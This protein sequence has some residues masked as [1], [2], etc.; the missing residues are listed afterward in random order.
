MSNLQMALETV[1]TELRNKYS[2]H[3]SER[4]ASWKLKLDYDFEYHGRWCHILDEAIND[5]EAI[6][7]GIASRHGKDNIQ[8][9]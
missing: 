1:L 6:L 7:E 9:C 8:S 4:D 3:D 5:T 2:F